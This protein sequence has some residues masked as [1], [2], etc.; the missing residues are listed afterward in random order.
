MLENEGGKKDKRTGSWLQSVWWEPAE[1]G[2][3]EGR[4][5]GSGAAGRIPSPRSSN[6]S[7]GQGNIGESQPPPKV[8]TQ[9]RKALTREEDEIL[10]N[11]YRNGWRGKR[12][13][14]R[15]ILGRHPDRSAQA[16]RRRARKLVGADD[17][18]TTKNEVRKPVRK[19]WSK[20]ELDLLLDLA[21]CRPMEDLAE[22]V[23]R[24]VRSV[25]CRLNRLGISG[26]V[27]EGQSLREL[28]RELHMGPNRVRKIINSGLL[29]VANGRIR[30]SSLLEFCRTKA[31]EL[32]IDVSRL[33]GQLRKYEQGYSPQRLGEILTVPVTDVARWT[34]EGLI[35]LRD[36]SLSVPSLRAFCEN[37]PEGI[38]VKPL[39]RELSKYNYSA[40]RVAKT[41]EVPLATVRLWLTKHWLKL[42]DQRISEKSIQE[43]YQNQSAKI[44]FCLLDTSLRKWLT[45]EMGAS[46]P[47]SL[48][49]NGMLRAFQRHAKTVRI[50]ACGRR[51][52]GNAWSRHV[53]RCRDCQTAVS[54]RY[55][56]RST[57]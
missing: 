3:F 10:R 29:R 47:K 24:S 46:E 7:K 11:G 48:E 22:L 50:T 13:A 37:H 12:E 35:Q 44:N 23:G 17:P 26:K 6:A 53:R 40:D 32:G 21:G 5:G 54:A 36:H 34:S 2:L 57:G 1:A 4:V 43:F 41:L 56:L 14:V 8:F 19:P 25:A 31:G 38:N 45:E 15:E 42:A 28:C 39:I 27:K 18:Q 9:T 49:E 20:Q 30:V 51:I 52:R 16:V 55:G 33:Q